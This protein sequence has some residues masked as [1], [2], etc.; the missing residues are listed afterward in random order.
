VPFLERVDRLDLANLTAD[1]SVNR[2][3][4]VD[5]PVWISAIAGVQLARAESD[6]QRAAR[7]FVGSPREEV[8]ELVGVVLRGAI[9]DALRAR[10]ADE[11][12][13]EPRL[14]ADQIV[15]VAEHDLRRFGIELDTLEVYRVARTRAT[16]E[17]VPPAPDRTKGAVAP[18]QARDAPGRDSEELARPKPS[19]FELPTFYEDDERS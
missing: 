12:E 15:E 14:L 5:V 6:L 8:R 10:T 18:E 13:R 17:K 7:N 11:A 1:V 19:E 9:R 3:L 2:A 16:A 4:T